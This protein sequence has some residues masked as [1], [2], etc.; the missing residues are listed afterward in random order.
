[1]GDNPN[2]V[3]GTRRPHDPTSR[4]H[5][6]TV[7]ELVA[8]WKACDGD[9]DFD[10]IIRLLILLPSR[11]SEVGGLCES[12]LD[13]K[14][15][16][17][18]LPKERSKNHRAHAIP[19]P[20]AALAIIASV[21]RTGRG[22]LFG[23]RAGSGFTSWTRCK[24]EL[25]AK[26]GDTVRPWKIHDLRRAVATHMAEALDVEPWHIEA[27]LNHYSSRSGTAETYNRSKY[28]R[29]IAAA[30]ARWSAYLTAR[31]EGRDDDDDNI[32]TLRA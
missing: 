20:D 25:D 7:A 3:D 6:P 30:L 15:G 27:C 22:H 10:K 31:I 9:G 19:L 28:Q 13:L 5:V 4:D 24:A 12:E 16:V 14:R 2:P 18:T 29:A 17:W 8:I 1:L 32:V 26:L 21:P 11:R 23:D